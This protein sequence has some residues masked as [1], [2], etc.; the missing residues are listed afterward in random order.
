MTTKKAVSWFLTEQGRN[1]SFAL[2]T[3]TSITLTAARYLPNTFFIQKYKEFVHYYKNGTPVELPKELLNRYNKCLD[4]LNVA[5]AHRK[6]IQPFSVFGFDL[7]HAGST[8]SK[9]GALVGIPCN[10]MFK[11][12]EDVKE[13]NIEVNHKPIDVSM[14]TGEKLGNALILSEGAQ[15]FAICREILMTQ[16]KKVMFE[17]AYPFISIFAVYN[18][19]CFFNRRFNLYAAP[20]AFR[21]TMY[22][23]LG[24]FGAGLYFLMKDMTQVHYEVQVDQ[25]LAELGPEYVKNG[26]EFYEKILKRNQALREL[27]GKE[28]ESKYTKLGNE[29]YGLRQPHVALVHRKKFFEEKLQKKEE[30]ESGNNY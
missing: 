30:I 6:L 21:G 18:M 28:G 8:S 5:D 26:V 13:C 9:F 29:N 3:G 19:G 11:T 24:F 1:F 25:K 12:L 22:T 2:I 14:E 7:F 4:L 15:E 27:M 10:F 23:I 20:T 16:N 17:S